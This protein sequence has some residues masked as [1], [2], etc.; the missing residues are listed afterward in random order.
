MKIYLTRHGETVWNQKNWVQGMTDIPLSENGL[1]QARQ[2]VEQMSGI[3]LDVVYTS[4]LQRAMV[5]GKMVADSHPE[6]RF[7]ICESINEM[8]FGKF[9]GKVRTDPEYQLEKR[10]YFKRYEGGESFLDVA[11]RVYPFIEMLKARNEDALVVAHNGICRVFTNYFQPM[12]NEEFASFALGN[13]E[14][15]IFT[16][17]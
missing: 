4:Q 13:C 11:A 3:H 2:L 7:E 17:C 14:V 15:K 12:D 1:C 5:T 6:C 10:K 16:I 8:N 9:E